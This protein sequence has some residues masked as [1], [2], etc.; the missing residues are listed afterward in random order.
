MSGVTVSDWLLVAAA[1]IGPILAVQAQKMVE[2]FTEDRRSKKRIFYVLMANRATQMAPDRV[3]ALNM[4]DLEFRSNASF[5]RRNRTK[6]ITDAWKILLDE[7]NS[8]TDGNPEQVKAWNRRCDELTVNLLHAMSQ[9][10][11]YDFDKVQLRRGIYY[12]KGHVD[13][14]IMQENILEN[15]NNIVKGEQS[16]GMHITSVP[17]SEEIVNLQKRVQEAFLGA[18][19]D[20]GQI[21]VALAPEEDPPTGRA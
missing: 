10:L 4:I 11:G 1:I 2:R 9:Y 8:G 3:Q 17:V 14:E 20:K 15:I 18:I 12:P 5:F 7:F 16:I 19:T 6:P 21:K 13:R